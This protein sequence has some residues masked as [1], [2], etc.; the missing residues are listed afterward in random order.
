MAGACTHARCLS[1][2]L[3]VSR[4]KVCT[5]ALL[6]CTSV[7]APRTS[8]VTMSTTYTAPCSACWDG[9]DAKLGWTS[10]AGSSRTAA[11]EARLELAGSCSSAGRSVTACRTGSTGAR[12]SSQCAGVR[13]SSPA[14]ARLRAAAKQRRARAIH[15][16]R[17][18]ALPLHSQLA[19]R[20][21]APL[22]SA[23]TSEHRALSSRMGNLQG[24]LCAP[25]CT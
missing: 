25:R 21:T 9:R 10:F 8:P 3:H 7:P 22:L 14:A 6:P 11:S 12:V 4:F 24:H 19:A 16:G 5:Q 15:G 20:I 1:Y 17:P 13:E 2:K 23:R 18:A